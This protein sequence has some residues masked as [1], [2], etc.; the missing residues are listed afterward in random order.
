MLYYAALRDRI[1]DKADRLRAIEGLERLRAQLD[2]AIPAKDAENSLL[3]ATWNIRDFDKGNRRGKGARLP[4]THFY[5][6][7]ILSRFDFVAVQEINALGEWANVMRLLGRDWDYIATDV[8]DE[9][10]GGN[11][12]RLTYLF[13][14]RKVL[15]QNIAGEIVLP[16]DMLI[17]RALVEPAHEKKKAVYAGKQ[18]RRSPFLAFFQAGWFKF[19]ICTVHIYFGE[20]S[21]AKLKERIEEIETV[22]AYFGARADR[23]LNDGRALILLGDFNIV[24]PEHK[25][26]K[27][28]TDNGFITPKALKTPT[29]VLSTKYYDQIAFKTEPDVIEFIESKNNAG[30]FPIFS[31]IMRESDEDFAAYWPIASKTT[32]G[33]KATDRASQQKVYRDW[34]TYQM[35]D[36]NPM[37]CRINANSSTGYLERLKAALES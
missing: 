34:R 21:G 22:A 4:E 33:K 5:I 31:E 13:D 27:A 2:A 37:W 16:M 12:E 19:A 24:H 35:S 32:S 15:F 11:G 3:L 23:E 26:M 8:T 25:T 6:A 20:E 9:R 1:P 17:S 7:E 30:V 29:N 14:R 10:L 36:H 18:F 28:L